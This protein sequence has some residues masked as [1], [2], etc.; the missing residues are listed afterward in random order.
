MYRF[1]LC[2]ALTLTACDEGTEYPSP[3]GADDTTPVDECTPGDRR[4]NADGATFYCDAHGQWAC[5]AG[6]HSE[7]LGDSELPHDTMASNDAGI[8]DGDDVGDVDRDDLNSDDSGPDDPNPDMPSPDDP[9]PDPNPEG[10]CPEGA[11]WLDQL[12]PGNEN[13]AEGLEYVTFQPN[14]SKYFCSRLP[15]ERGN[16]KKLRYGFSG[17]GNDHTCESMML[18]VVAVPPEST[19]DRSRLATSELGFRSANVAVAFYLRDADVA[20]DAPPGLYV[21]KATELFGERDPGQRVCR[22]FQIYKLLIYP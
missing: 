22:R 16:A 13:G 20:M 14:E 8:G 2:F 9:S 21:I 12:I 10:Q 5:Q 6:T 19:A 4:I 1:I 11:L 3:R 15:P 7:G 18:E 17:H